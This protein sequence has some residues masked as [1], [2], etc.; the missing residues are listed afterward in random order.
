M[1]K[2]RKEK[3]DNNERNK[4]GNIGFLANGDDYMDDDLDGKGAAI[5]AAQ[6]ATAK[7]KDQRSKTKDSGKSKTT[8][9][10]RPT[11]NDQS[12]D[13]VYFF[14]LGGLEHVGQNMYVYKYRGKYLVV[15]AG[16]GFLEGEFEGADTK[17]PDTK[18]LE[19][20]KKDVLA[21]VITHGHEDHTGALKYIW[22]KFRA[23]IYCTRF[24]EKFM[25]KTFNGVGIETKPD[26]F[27]IFNHNGDNF[28]IGPFEL[29]TFHVSHSVPEANM[30]VIKTAQGKILH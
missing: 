15:D 7:T 5:A 29:E 2:L 24:V 13:T 9:D 18:F 17:Y 28:N 3:N 1:V 23:P 22:E 25:R 26:D 20:H 19:K 27:R 4:I 16:M 30:I 6:T 21:F 14:A 8:N 11:T 12:D 10:Q